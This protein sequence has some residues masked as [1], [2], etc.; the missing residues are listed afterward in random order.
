MYRLS[1]YH[2]T[3]P[4][5]LGMSDP[6]MES[7]A[8]PR[9]FPTILKTLWLISMSWLQISRKLRKETKGTKGTKKAKGTRGMNWMNWTNWANWTNW[10]KGCGLWVSYLIS[11]N[12][13]LFKNK[14]HVGSLQ[15]F[16]FAFAIS[17][18]V[19]IYLLLHR[20]TKL[21][22]TGRLSSWMFCLCLCVCVFVISRWTMVL[23][24][25][26]R[27][28]GGKA[29]IVWMWLFIDDRLTAGWRRRRK[30]RFRV[31]T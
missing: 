18:F 14:A 11:L 9:N 29:E 30:A 10:T 19:Y 7:L 4:S 20:V 5:A 2:V 1:K 31:A 15:Y 3:R 12:P 27:C 25:F 17:L 24:S 21:K 8:I 13:L 22:N 16:V 26:R 6:V 28:V 23:S